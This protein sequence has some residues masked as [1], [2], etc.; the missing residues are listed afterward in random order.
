MVNL[1]FL[2]VKI[3]FPNIS[4]PKTQSVH[5]LCIKILMF[6]SV[7]K[8]GDVKPTIK[9]SNVIKFGPVSEQGAE[10]TLHKETVIFNFSFH[11]GMGPR[12]Q[13]LSSWP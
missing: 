1:H 4:S 6:T 3:P 7:Q 2:M 13:N 5:L 12:F 9:K 8:F 11:L 10:T